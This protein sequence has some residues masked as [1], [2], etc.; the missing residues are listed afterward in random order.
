LTRNGCTERRG[1]LRQQSKSIRGGLLEC[2]EHRDAAVAGISDRLRTAEM[3][4][5]RLR[6][7]ND[8][9]P[10]ERQACEER[11]VR[12]R[13]RLRAAHEADHAVLVLDEPERARATKEEL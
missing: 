12:V 3:Q 6:D 7:R 2:L 8:A 5:Q 10:A 13:C 1:Q 4:R 11:P 9:L